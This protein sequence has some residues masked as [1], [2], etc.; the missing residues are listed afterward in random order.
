MPL[1]SRAW[2][3]RPTA[4]TVSGLASIRRARSSTRLLTV[5]LAKGRASA[6]REMAVSNW[7]SSCRLGRGAPEASLCSATME[8]V[9]GGL[10]PGPV[11][12]L[13]LTVVQLPGRR[14]SDIII[15]LFLSLEK[16]PQ[17]VGVVTKEVHQA[18]V[19][20][21]GGALGDLVLQGLLQFV[22]LKVGMVLGRFRNPQFAHHPPPGVHPEAAGIALGI[23]HLP[24]EK[25]ADFLLRGVGIKGQHQALVGIE[26]VAALQQL[27]DIETRRPVGHLPEIHH[28]VVGDKVFRVDKAKIYIE[29]L[30]QLF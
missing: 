18:P 29:G 15:Q 25:I 14:G 23:H 12:S 19:G 1:C 20:A 8:V 11:Y 16:V 22:E 27:E 21:E 26:A 28:I 3:R 2:M 7:L 9:L 13:F 30:D 4:A 10:S 24:G 5:A 6:S 17:L